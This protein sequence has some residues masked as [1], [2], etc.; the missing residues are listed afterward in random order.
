MS[1]ADCS[2]AN[3][4]ALGETDGRSGAPAKA[5]S[6]RSKGC[7][8]KGEP[9]DAAAYEAGRTRGL[10]AF[11]AAEGGFEAGKS[12]VKYDRVCPADEEPAFLAAYA[13][14]AHLAALEDASDRAAK[15]YDKAV[16]DLD[17][18][19][20]LLSVAEKRYAKPSISNADR[21]YERQDVEFRRREI[22]RLETNL[23][24]MAAARDAAKASLDAFRA[25]L[26]AIGRTAE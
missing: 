10:A 23:P 24:R 22:A 20:Y 2:S 17:Q 5:F 4:A 18:H 9:V 6:A 14:G 19:R 8:E 3:W 12:G 11:C 26:A 15:T 25:E 21:E 7:A 13:R 16:A 1:I